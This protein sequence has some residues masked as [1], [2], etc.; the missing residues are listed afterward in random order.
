MSELLIK[1]DDSPTYKDGDILHAYTDNH[2]LIKAAERLCHPWKAT[3]N[4]HGLLNLETKEQ[5]FFE[6]THQYKFIRSGSQVTRIELSTL[7]EEDVSDQM[8]VTLYISRR[9]QNLAPNGAAKKALFGTPGNEIWYGGTFD[10]TKASVVWDMLE[11]KTAEIRT[12]YKNYPWDLQILREYLVVP[13]D[14]ITEERASELTSAKVDDTDPEN[15]ITIAKRAHKV[16]WRPL[17]A[18]SGFTAADVENKQKAVDLR[19]DAALRQADVVTK[20]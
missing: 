9:I 14:P 13:I 2:I 6:L 17:F 10:T 15:I 3:P 20:K 12:N 8:D 18:R 7:Q 4:E 5:D 1:I 11:Q 19:V 16:T